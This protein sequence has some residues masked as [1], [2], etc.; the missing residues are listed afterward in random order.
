[1]DKNALKASIYRKE[2]GETLKNEECSYSYMTH[3]FN[4][5]TQYL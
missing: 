4:V 1:M 3:F 2:Q 5:S